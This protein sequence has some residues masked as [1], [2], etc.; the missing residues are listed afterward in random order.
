MLIEAHPVSPWQAN[1]YL[2]AAGSGDS[3]QP[4]AC[5]VVD[6]GIASL[7]VITH[8]LEGRRWQPAAVVLTHGHIDHAGDAHA[9]AARWGVPVYCAEADQPM[10]QRPSLGLGTSFV[11]IIEEFL[12]ADALPLPA[13]LRPLV[14]PFEVAGLRVRPHRA[15]GHTQGSTLLEVSD[16]GSSVVFTGDVVFAGTI[17]RTDLPGGNMSEMRET[18]RRIRSSFPEDVPLLPG[19]GPDTTLAAERLSNSYLHDSY[20]HHEM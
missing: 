10:L 1:C 15:P 4:T 14:E 18:L 20:L 6:P 11:G 19:H 9:V 5:L 7:D 12:G 8:A 3:A 2:V 16:G 13:D 17:G